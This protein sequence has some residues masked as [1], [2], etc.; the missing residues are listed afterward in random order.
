MTSSTDFYFI[1][2]VNKYKECRSIQV[3]I[4]LNPLLVLSE[5]PTLS[6]HIPS[7]GLC[8]IGKCLLSYLTL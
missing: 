5:G 1:G 6:R 7:K 3:R 2:V 8:R 4:H